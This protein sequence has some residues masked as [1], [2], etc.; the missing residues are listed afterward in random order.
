MHLLLRYGPTA[1]GL[2]TPVVLV[3]LHRAFKK[4]QDDPELT[5]RRVLRKLAV[6]IVSDIADRVRRAV[7]AWI[8]NGPIRGAVLALAEF[9]EV[10]WRS[11]RDWRSP[12]QSAELSTLGLVGWIIRTAP[13]QCMF[14][15]DQFALFLVAV[16]HIR[17]GD[18]QLP[19]VGIAAVSIV[20]LLPLLPAL[21]RPTKLA[22]WRWILA[23]YAVGLSVWSGHSILRPI[24]PLNASM[25]M[26]VYVV[27]PWLA[28][29]YLVG[30]LLLTAKRGGT[31][32]RTRR[33]ASP[34]FFTLA[35]T[36]FAFYPNNPS[37]FELASETFFAVS[38]LFTGIAA[39]HD[40]ELALAR[41]RRQP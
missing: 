28:V 19:F 39:L 11:L 4:S 31:G 41:V 20:G 21:S 32:H 34:A 3:A 26:K 22:T 5:I 25:A 8:D 33:Y 30:I 17:S 12:D 2:A 13:L 15:I 9:F 40:D 6:G 23:L 16:P 36:A 14:V 7:D 1:T 38:A 35:L 24:V 27:G 18:L 10:A 37:M 29:I